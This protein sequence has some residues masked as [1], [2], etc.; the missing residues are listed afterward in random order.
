MLKQGKE[1]ELKRWM[2]RKREVINREVC[3]VVRLGREMQRNYGGKMVKKGWRNARRKE[4]TS[5][6]LREEK[7]TQPTRVGSAQT[8]RMGGRT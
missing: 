1:Q 8:E 6:K 3:E 2:E 7:V 4:R 5:E